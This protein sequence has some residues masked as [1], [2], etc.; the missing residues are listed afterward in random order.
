MPA[1][2]VNAVKGEGEHEPIAI[3]AVMWLGSSKVLPSPTQPLARLMVL[4]L[5]HTWLHTSHWYQQAAR[6]QEAH[7]AGL[8]DKA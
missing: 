4:P 7:S 3:G 5:L 6:R 8:S 2:A 1:L